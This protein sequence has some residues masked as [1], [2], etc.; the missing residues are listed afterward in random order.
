MSASVSKNINP[1]VIRAD[2]GELIGTGHIFRC[3]SLAQ[4]WRSVHGEAS[5]IHLVT[6]GLPKPLKKLAVALRIKVFQLDLNMGDFDDEKSTAQVCADA[7][8]GKVEFGWAILD[9]YQFKENLIKALK[10]KGFRVLLLDD[11]QQLEHYSADLVLNQNVY[12]SSAMYTSKEPAVTLLL[13]PR[14]ALLRSE[15]SSEVNSGVNEVLEIP[16]ILLSMGGSDP[17]NATSHFLK[18]IAASES[19]CKVL[20]VVGAA[21]PHLSEIK[22]TIE[23]FQLCAEI[24]INESRISELMERSSLAICAGGTMVYELASLGVP[25]LLCEIADNQKMVV[26]GMEEAGASISLG[27]LEE[28][29]V[30][31][32]A[33]EFSSLIEDHNKMKSMSI[34]AKKLVD[35]N[36]SRRV[37]AAMDSLVLHIR[38]VNS[39]DAHLTFSW[40]NSATNRTASFYQDPIAW[41]EHKIWFERI[42]NCETS[43]YLVFEMPDGQPV[44]QV[45][46]EGFPSTTLSLFL[47]KQWQGRGLGE[48]LLRRSIKHAEKRG[49]ISIR[50]F[51]RP[52][53]LKSV[54][55]FEGV[56]F[57]LRQDAVINDQQALY[58]HFDLKET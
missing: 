57:K 25:S 33:K 26:L 34:A 52:E 40:A 49:V 16:E 14:F 50:A 4:M 15:F 30:V 17:K 5:V 41:E 13:G 58:Y 44:G 47:D 48:W 1:L 24:R 29:S 12:A 37:V 38:P 28:L 46:L 53:N 8:G 18:G 6:S 10:D 3:F 7:L 2:A 31:E 51:I 55:I 11:N 42:L 27:K 45:R 54:K 35:G 39:D 19:K 32:I 22:H 36:G 9:G 21:N 56:G 23:R 20:V 43:E